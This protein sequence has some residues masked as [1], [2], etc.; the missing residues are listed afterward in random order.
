MYA[1][2]SLHAWNTNETSNT[3]M[4][5]RL[6]AYLFSCNVIHTNVITIPN[7]HRLSNLLMYKLC[8][9]LWNC[10]TEKGFSIYY[11]MNAQTDIPVR[12]VHNMSLQSC[13]VTRIGCGVLFLRSSVTVHTSTSVVLQI[14]GLVKLSP[15]MLFS[16]PRTFP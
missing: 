10:D 7:I 13:T 15:I 16:Y 3:W 1:V 14:F 11:C 2:I 9:F 6:L 8:L 5:R 12:C 4:T